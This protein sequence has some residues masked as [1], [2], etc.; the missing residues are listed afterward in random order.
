MDSEGLLW[1]FY[2]L[3][4]SHGK[5]GSAMAI[6]QE[7]L[8]VAAWMAEHTLR[9]PGTV[10][11]PPSDWLLRDDAFA[12]QMAY[13]DRL[14]AERREA[15]HGLLPGAEPAA[16]EL[17]A[18]ILADLE[19]VAGY[20][21]EGRALR[22]PDGVLVPLD[23]P[24]LAVA[25]RLVQEDLCLMEKGAEESEHRLTG[26]VLCFPSNWTLAEKL[27]HPLV[28]IHLPVP[29]Y[30]ETVARR[31]QR[32]FDAIRPEE[33]LMRSN[34]IFSAH[35]DL[36]NARHEFDRHTPQAGAARFLRVERQVLL[37]LPETRAVVFSIHTFMVRPE[38]LDPDQRAGLEAAFPGAFVQERTRA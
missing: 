10:P 33:P 27:G 28:R 15:V 17:L 19:S 26:A 6:L 13:R 31:V 7:R 38:A 1:S 5:E 35:E 22:R 36:F 32:L 30:D 20:V 24:P 11:I 2:I 3:A 21:R 16:A 18:R 29:R 9:L 37:R 25:G 8:P 23:G 12:V 4:G 14:L 34:V